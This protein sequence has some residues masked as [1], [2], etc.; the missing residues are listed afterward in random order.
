MAGVRHEIHG[1]TAG[2]GVSVTAV[3]L[4]RRPAAHQANPGSV[5]A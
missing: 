2:Y 5:S 4:I 3:S 1:F